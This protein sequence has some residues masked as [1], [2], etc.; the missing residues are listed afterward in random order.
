MNNYLD[1]EYRKNCRKVLVQFCYDILQKAN[2]PDNITAFTIKALHLVFPFVAFV[3]FLFAPFKLT[4]VLLPMLLFFIA[5]FVY[6]KG[7]FV[8]HLEYKLCPT[9]FINIMDPYLAVLGWP[10]NDENRHTITYILMCIY[11]IFVVSI[12]YYRFIY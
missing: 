6:L 1:D 9:D 8:S 2:L 12:I 3:V 5:L 4:M 10:I 7:C 11:F